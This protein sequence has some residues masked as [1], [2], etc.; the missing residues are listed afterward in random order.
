MTEDPEQLKQAVLRK[1]LFDEAFYEANYGETIPPGEPGV[2]HFARV[3][4][5]RGF[6]P[7]AAFDPVLH[8]VLHGPTPPSAWPDRTE[9][10]AF[11]PVAAE[12]FPALD[13][14][15]YFWAGKQADDLKANL[16]QLLANPTRS[17]ELPTARGVYKFRNPASEDVFRSIRKGRPFAFV[18][19]PHGFWDSCN[20]VDRVSRDLAADPR[21]RRLSDARRRAL[22]I[23]LLGG[24]ERQSGNFGGDYLDTVLD[25]L[26][27]H[28]RDETL[29]TGIAFKGSPTY[30]DS[31]FGL[32]PPTPHNLERA[33]TFMRLF[34][35]EDRLYDAMVWKRWAI[36]GGL[37]E[38]PRALRDKPLI[39]VARESFSILAERL[40]LPQLVMVDI[41]PIK[42]QL[43]RRPVLARIEAAIQDQ[44]DRH[45]GQTPVV[46]FQA[47]ASL[48]YWF[49]RRLRLRFPGVIYLDLGEA[50]SIWCLDK[51]DL[52]LWLQPYFDQITKA[53]LAPPDP[54]GADQP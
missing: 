15:V 14:Q 40:A 18:R 16:G 13:F 2:D 51:S 45:P 30:E 5:E 28:P 20:V 9:A 53:T 50:L 38:L 33:A 22:A 39:L 11:R 1:G 6:A 24:R 34:S 26:A 49:I 46:L 54:V 37:R 48:G 10:E 19:I 41:P 8:E 44:I 12:L 36:L 29:L 27:H 4:H 35:P 7:S 43:I 32:G 3:G 21:A 25:D 52:T 23:R 31:A 17:V 47:G 42:T